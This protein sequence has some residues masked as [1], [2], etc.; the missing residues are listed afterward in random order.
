MISPSPTQ[1]PLPP[2]DNKEIQTPPPVKTRKRAGETPIALFLKNL[3]RPIIKGL[4][5]LVRI[6][7]RHFVFALVALLL[8]VLSIFTT[9]YLFTKQVPYNVGRDQFQLTVNGK[10][11]AGGDKIKNWLYHL[12]E[13]NIVA[14]SLDQQNI[15][16]ATD[17]QQLVEAF[18]EAKSNLE[19]KAINVVSSYSES[20]TTVDTFVAINYVSHGPGGDTK[21]LVIW[22]FVTLAR[23]SESML[24]G[25]NLVNNRPTL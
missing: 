22:H 7:R 6:I 2:L 3:L 24:L 10:M 8:L 15:K 1:R 19:W 5:Y 12:R 21:G 23:D 25:A 17:P 20:D 14:L 13:G 9:N 11:V 18:S 16:Q 4:Y